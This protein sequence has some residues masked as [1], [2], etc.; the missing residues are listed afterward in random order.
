[1]VVIWFFMIRPQAKKQK[2]TQ[3]MLS[4]LQPRDKVVTIGGLIGEIDS[5]K[6]ENTVVIK[7][8]KDVKLELRKN[9]IASKI[10]SMEAVKK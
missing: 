6:D 10:E 3:K 4:S 7:V 2:E 8:G 1:M 5:L 9:A